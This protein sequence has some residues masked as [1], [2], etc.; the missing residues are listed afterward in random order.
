V[1]SAVAALRS[2]N[3]DYLEISVME[4]YMGLIRM[5]NESIDE[6]HK[7]LL[8]KRL[9]DSGFPKKTPEDF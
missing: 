3:P 2:I 1:E 8:A 6:K 7:I 9:N 4:L 5:T